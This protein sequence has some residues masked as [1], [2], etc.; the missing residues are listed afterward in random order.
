MQSIKFTLKVGGFAFFILIN[1]IACESE[2]QEK[3]PTT[4]EAQENKVNDIVTENKFTE[5]IPLSKPFEIVKQHLKNNHYLLF[6]SKKNEYRIVIPTSVKEIKENPELVENNLKKA[7]IIFTIRAFIHTPSDEI[8]FVIYPILAENLT[9]KDDRP[10]K[11]YKKNLQITRK[12]ALEVISESIAIDKFD[13]L[14]G[15]YIDEDFKKDIPNEKFHKIIEVNQY[16]GLEKMYEMMF[17]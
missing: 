3:S 2:I 10:I 5:N 16:P 12:K 17:E 11:M 13:E 15:E 6:L 14:I 1:F 7:A 8:K 9:N 4:D